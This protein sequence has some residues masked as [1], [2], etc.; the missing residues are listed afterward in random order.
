M[1]YAPQVQTDRCLN[2]RPPD[3]DSTFHVTETPALTTWPSV[4]S[5]TWKTVFRNAMI[6]GLRVTGVLIMEDSVP[7]Y[8]DCKFRVASTMDAS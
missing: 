5:D 6:V 4:T 7:E 8:C 2:S 1:Y 3:H